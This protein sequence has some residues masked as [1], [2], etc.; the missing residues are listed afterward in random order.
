MVYLL[1][2]SFLTFSLNID[3]LF[4]SAYPGFIVFG[5]V[6]SNSYEAFKYFHISQS[7]LFL[8]Y[9]NIVKIVSFLGNKTISEDQ[10]V[11]LCKT[12]NDVTYC[13]KGSEVILGNNMVKIIKLCIEI[14]TNDVLF[15]ISM[16]CDQ[17]NYF[18]TTFNSM[19]TPSLCLKPIEKYIFRKAVNSSIDKILSFQ[20]NN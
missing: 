8:F 18:L 7:E 12:N 16:S 11:F 13:W 2:K 4:I 9:E 19:I 1:E 20:S 17:F 10:S 6:K 5:E 3:Y 15:E 14:Q